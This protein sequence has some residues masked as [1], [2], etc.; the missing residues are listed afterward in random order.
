V[1]AVTE[2]R[3]YADQS[4]SQSNQQASATPGGGGPVAGNWRI[5]MR[6][7]GP[8][9]DLKVDLNSD[10][11]LAQDDIFL[12]LTVGLTRTELDQTQNSGVGSAVALEALG[13]LSGAEG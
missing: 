10:P 11:P 2:Y 6:A 1:S 8:P 12:L 5:V 9:E 13:S 3:R 7:Y 4:S